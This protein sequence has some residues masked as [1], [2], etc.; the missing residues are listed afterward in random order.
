M[1]SSFLLAVVT[2]RRFF[3]SW[4]A[5]ASLLYSPILKDIWLRGDDSFVGEWL[6]LKDTK[7]FD[8][9]FKKSLDSSLLEARISSNRGR[10]FHFFDS[11]IYFSYWNSIG[12][13]KNNAFGCL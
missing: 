4:S 5:A 3:I 8:E 9:I 10:V 1:A 2:R 6:D 11:Q 7:S 12:L 13:S